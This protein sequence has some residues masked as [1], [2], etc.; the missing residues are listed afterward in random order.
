MPAEP[1]PTNTYVQS[2]DAT[3]QIIAYVRD[4]K[5]FR[6]NSYL[7]YR[8]AKQMV[9]LYCVL[10]RDNQ[11]RVVTEAE[12]A[13]ADGQARPDG[14]NN[15]D[16][17]DLREY[18][19]KRFDIPF[20]VGNLTREQAS[21]DIVASQAAGRMQQYMT[22]QTL[23]AIQT[24]ETAGNWGANTN[25]ANVLNDGAGFWDTSDTAS[26][27]IQKSIYAAI[28]AVMLAT[29][30]VVTM[31]EL[32]LVIGVKAARRLRTAREITDYIKGSPQALAQVRGELPNPNVEF[33]LPAKLFGVELVVENAVRVTSR[34]TTSGFNNGTRS[35]IKD[36]S[37]AVLMSKV[38]AL[39]GDQVNATMPTPN[40]STLQVFY[41]DGPNTQN[42][43]SEA[44]GP[45]GLYTVETFEDTRNKRLDGHVV[46]NFDRRLVAPESGYLITN[47][48]SP[49][50]L[51]S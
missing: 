8:P 14:Y 20:T 44:E 43:N 50:A 15:L 28:E 22:L 13:W 25:D 51:A 40:F 31:D 34:K 26:N 41:Y 17:F 49:A 35:F 32:R 39:P 1:G 6:I 47:I 48:L 36:P 5:R 16:A 19:T 11:A 2:L 45:S 30:G 4:P 21:W 46:T 33:G 9:G 23:L 37:S 27:A 7:A 38:D 3:G 18:R 29:N 10:D 12:F 42:N 24:L